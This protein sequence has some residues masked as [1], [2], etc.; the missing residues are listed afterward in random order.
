MKKQLHR[1][2]AESGTTIVVAL[3]TTILLGGFVA[4][5]VEYTGNIGRNAQRD[6]VFAEAVEIGDGYLEQAFGSWRQ[7]SKASE[8]PS[9]S[10]FNAMPT[11]SPGNF[12]SFPNA[13]VTNFRVQAVDPV[14]SLASD[15]PPISSLAT[16]DSPPKTTGPGNGTFSYFYL[17]T[18]DVKLPYTGGFLTA[19]VRRIFEKRYTSAWNWAMLYNEDLELHPDSKLALDGWVHSNKNVYIG[20]GAVPSGTPDGTPFPT[21]TPNLTLNDRLTYAGNYTMGFSPNDPDHVSQ[22]NMADAVAPADLPPG[23]EQ[24]YSPFGWSTAQFNTGDSNADNDGFREMIEKPSSSWGASSTDPFKTDRLYNQA[25]LVVEIYSS[26]DATYPDRIRVYA[27][28]AVGGTRTSVIN[29]QPSSGTKSR[30]AWDLAVAALGTNSAGYFA[31]KSFQDNR[32][33][34]TVSVAN[35]NVGNLKAVIPGSP[36]AWNGVLY[37]T[38]TRGGT[39]RRGVRITNGASVPS[40]G[41]TIVSDNPVYIQGDFNTGRTSTVEPPSNT[42]DPTNPQAGTYLRAPASIMGDAVTLLSNNWT[43]TNAGLGVTARVAKNTTVNAALVT[44]NV[45]SNGV[46]YSGG[47]EN[48]IRLLEDW[49][50]PGATLTYY[51]SMLGLYESKQAT[52]LWGNANVYAPPQLQLF[53]DKKLSVDSSGNAITVP[54]FVSTVAYLQQQRWYLQY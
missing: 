53:F 6:R 24:V 7:L 48:L 47:G 42:G 45:A 43:D 33:G 40:T 52:G 49:E 1:H 23:R 29:S 51:G 31:P 17:A 5:A 25:G 16:S 13:V 4:L 14:I 27:D 22:T 36:L 39:S 18:V 30:E 11:P 54:G 26:G 41:L 15:N 20:N 21:P 9:T 35:V 46:R 12:P 10:A 44:G 2:Q 50:A 3:M 38:D 32:A 37:V 34:G 28:D 8:A 19:K